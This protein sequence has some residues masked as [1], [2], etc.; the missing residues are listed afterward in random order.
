[1]KYDLFITGD[2]LGQVASQTPKALRA[3]DSVSTTFIAR[4]LI[5]DDKNTIIKKAVSI[6]TYDISIMPGE[7]MCSNFTP[8]SPIIAPDF[9]IVLNLDNELLEAENL[10]ED[11]NDNYTE[12]I[13]LDV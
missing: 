2:A 11:I 1:M 4:P 7:D 5:G 13:D 8:P 6:G 12:R 10:F 3:V 9:S